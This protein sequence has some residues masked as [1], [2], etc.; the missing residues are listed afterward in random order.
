[1]LILGKL[2]SQAYLSDQGNGGDVNQSLSN[3]HH[4]I[5]GGYTSQKSHKHDEKG[6]MIGNCCHDVVLAWVDLFH[7]ER[8]QYPT[9]L[10]KLLIKY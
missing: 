7:G 5:A 10:E 3:D 2:E 4:F 8:Y 6:I 9:L 1:L